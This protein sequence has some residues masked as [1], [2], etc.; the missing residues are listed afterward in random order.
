MGEGPLTS[1]RGL[2]EGGGAVERVYF[3]LR[4]DGHKV[5]LFLC[6][7]VLVKKQVEGGPKHESV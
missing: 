7:S 4:T 2:G 5:H 3:R 1:T 6:P